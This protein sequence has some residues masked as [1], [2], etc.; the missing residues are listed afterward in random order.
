MH[1]EVGV[2][3]SDASLF[4]R[5][6]CNRYSA[7]EIE[8]VEFTNER[9]S[10]LA[11]V[12]ALKKLAIDYMHPE[13]EVISTGGASFGRNYYNRFSAP[14]T[15]DF[16]V[17]EERT[18]VLAEAAALEKL[19]IHYMHPEIAFVATVGAVYGHNFFLWP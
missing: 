5:N 7:P 9:D 3:T 14:E 8:D 17:A 15:E 6:Y 19:A 18:R 2:T 16:E 12:A 10:V 4:G 11:K 1:P 13:I